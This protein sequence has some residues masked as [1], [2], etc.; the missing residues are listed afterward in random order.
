MGDEEGLKMMHTAGHQGNFSGEDVPW[1]ALV[2]E[3]VVFRLC[4]GCPYAAR[5]WMLLPFGGSVVW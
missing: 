1:E 3:P 2:S 4:S 5:M